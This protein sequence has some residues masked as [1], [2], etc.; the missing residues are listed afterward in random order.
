MACLLTKGDLCLYPLLDLVPIRAPKVIVKYK[1]ELVPF[2]MALVLLLFCRTSLGNTQTPQEIYREAANATVLLVM[3]DT[4]DQT[5]G[6][7]SGFFVEVDK[8]ATNFHVIEGAARGIAKHVGQETRYTIEGFCAVNE[9][10]DLVVLQ[11]SA[12]SVQP[13]TIADSDAVEIGE[14]IYVVGN[15]KGYLEGTFSEGIISGIRLEETDK[16]LQLTAPISPGSSGGPVLN[17][18]G[19]VIGISVATIKSGQNLNFAIPSNFLKDLLA[20]LHSVIPFPSAAEPIP[21]ASDWNVAKAREILAAAIDAHGGLE[22]LKQVKTIVSIGEIVMSTP[23]GEMAIDGQ[24]TVVLPG[25]AR[26][27]MTIPAM[28]M[29]MSRVLGEQSAWMASPQGTQTMPEVF[30]QEGRNEL[31]RLNPRLLTYVSNADVAVQHLGEE[32]VNGKL[33]DV[34][35]V[36]DTPAGSIKLF[37]DQESKYIVKREFQALGQQGEPVQREEFPGDYRDIAG[38]KIAFSVVSIDNGEKAAEVTL[39]EVTI[40]AE[41]DESIFEQ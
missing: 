9:K 2:F 29:T 7:G 21:K 18:K 19:E 25:K 15:P 41:V 23:A 24:V 4:N 31:F 17:N 1:K 3:K 30:A 38:V 6:Y 28:G 34:V 32:D 8:I 11:V 12:S 13:L 27:D 10:R 39:S 36:S 22:N 14:T 33:A 5:L 20:E 26:Y 37:I 16:L 35:L 40:N